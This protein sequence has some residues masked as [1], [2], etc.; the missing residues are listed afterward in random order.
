MKKN[1]EEIR[2]MTFGKFQIA[3]IMIKRIPKVK[4]T[5]KNIRSNP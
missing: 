1:K 2:K 5:R 4:K 3:A